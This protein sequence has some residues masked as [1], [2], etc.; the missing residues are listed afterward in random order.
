[1][2]LDM[3]LP[4]LGP[5]PLLQSESVRAQVPP[6]L[7]WTHSYTGVM[8][9]TC[10]HRSQSPTAGHTLSVSVGSTL[11]TG[12]TAPTTA[13]DDWFPDDTHHSSLSWSDV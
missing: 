10:D 5:A 9:M 12:F 7:H 8:T 13:R 11:V 2:V 3:K 6:H 1:M 4:L